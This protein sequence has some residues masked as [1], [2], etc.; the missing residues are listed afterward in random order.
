VTAAQ[1]VLPRWRGFNLLEMF[2]P[3]SNSEWRED[4]FA[5][6]RDFGFDFVRLPMC[7]WLWSD[8]A[9]PLSIREEALEPI[10]R[11]VNMGQAKGLHVC[12]NF[13]RA[14][15]YTVSSREPEPLN[16]WKSPEAQK[17][18]CSHWATFAQ[19]YRGIGAEQLSFNLV[20]EPA[21]IT[22]LMSREDHERVMRT[23]ISE[24]RKI[25]PDRP[26]ILDGLAYAT[27]PCPELA[28]TGAAQSCRAYVP[29]PVSHYKAWWVNGEDWPEPTWPLIEPHGHRWDRT[30]LE[31][32]YRPWIELASRGVGVHCGEGGALAHT[33]HHV[34]LAWLRDVLEILTEAGIGLA[35]WNFR[36]SFGILDSRRADVTYEDFHGHQLDRKLLDLL[37]E[38]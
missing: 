17:A 8:P 28:D 11:A 31:E 32:H 16:L 19:R 14:P 15:G 13:H 2:Q 12:L 38:F 36:G 7:Y 23:A 18:F 29:L 21:H 27:E 33:P 1:S 24:V 22:D 35:L 5:W 30:R 3:K 25:D 4:D 34:V 37:Q 6:I 26:I 9:D 20:N 10:D